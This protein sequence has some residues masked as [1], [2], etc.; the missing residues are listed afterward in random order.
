MSK[1]TFVR[2]WGNR[3]H[4]KLKNAEACVL[5]RSELLEYLESF[6]LRKSAYQQAITCTFKLELAKNE[7]ISLAIFSIIFSKPWMKT[8]YIQQSDNMT[9][10]QAFQLV[11]VVMDNIDNILKDK[12]AFNIGDQ[13]HLFGNL[14]ETDIKGNC[15]E[16]GNSWLLE[17]TAIMSSHIFEMLETAKKTLNTQYTSYLRL[18]S[19]QLEEIEKQTHSAPIYNIISEESVGMFSASLHRAPAATILFHASKIKSIKN[20]TISMIKTR[21]VAEQ[22][23]I[24][25]IAIKH[26]RTIKYNAIIHAKNI[27]IKIVKRIRIHGQ[28]DHTKERNIL[29]SK[30]RELP[31]NN[32]IQSTFNCTEEESKVVVNILTDQGIFMSM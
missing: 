25:K 22:K 30:I 20:N 17:D 1:S 15:I 23:R 32:N 2:V 3:L 14:I 6:C 13:R 7:L 31:A 29:E 10:F 11:K 12:A 18:S 21:T 4:V 16:R 19:Q 8:F 5:F 9:H 28:I 26:S 27:H 24:I